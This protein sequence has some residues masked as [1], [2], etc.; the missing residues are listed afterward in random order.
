MKVFYF[1]RILFNL[2]VLII[3]LIKVTVL[4]LN[5]KKY[6]V[7]IQLEGGFGHTVSEPHYLNITEKKKWILILA[8]EKKFHNHKVKD[9]FYPNII[10]I[11]K[12][13]IYWAKQKQIENVFIFIIKKIHSINIL[14]IWSYIMSKKY[15]TK[16]NNYHKCLESRE[17]REFYKFRN[18]NLY[19]NYIDTVESKKI[20]KNLKYSKGIINFQFRAKGKKT[21][22]F[23]KY[24]Q[25]RDSEDINYYKPSIEALIANGWAIIFGGEEFEIPNWFNKI[26]DKLIYRS[27]LNLDRYDYGMLAG[28]KT[29][30]YIGP[31]SG[32]GLFNLI[33]SKKKQLFLNCLP[34]GFGYI[35]SVMSYPIMSFK[36][37][38]DFKK[39]FEKNIVD[40]S[41]FNFYED[42]LVRKLNSNEVKDIILD[43][44]N[45]INR[46]YGLSH[47]D[48][49]IKN[50]IME[51]TN[52]KVSEKWLDLINYKYLK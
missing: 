4:L 12:T 3:D 41:S 22:T 17:F 26:E 14:P 5:K 18:H 45:N 42:R 31:S 11:N 33:N 40:R 23:D 19:Q 29:D 1:F 47:K 51:D 9:I 6:K 39:V 7:F 15:E 27:K 35:G 43:F 34:F 8:L 13:S 2:F 44:L 30:I 52:F 46:N 25:F 36:N 16:K 32:G 24:S 37:K 21:G 38:N 28:L 20:F 50:G 10:L 49:D 48:L